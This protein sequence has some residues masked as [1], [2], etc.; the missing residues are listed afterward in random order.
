MTKHGWEPGRRHADGRIEP[1]SPEPLSSDELLDVDAE[2]WRWRSAHLEQ[3]AKIHNGLLDPTKLEAMPSALWRKLQRLIRAQLRQ[4]QWSR[5]QIQAAHWWAVSKAS[6]RMPLK[7][8][9]EYAEDSLRGTP[10]EAGYE[11]IR[12]NYYKMKKRLGV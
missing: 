6:K 5:E 2:F 3:I 9:V 12:Q 11:T 10:F 1:A 4:C 8:A 7:R